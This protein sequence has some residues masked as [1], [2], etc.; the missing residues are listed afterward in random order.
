MQKQDYQE[1]GEP[2]IKVEDGSLLDKEDEKPE[3]SE[4]A[5]EDEDKQMPEFVA[6]EA[7][8]A[9][10]GF[11]VLQMIASVGAGGFAAYVGHFNHETQCSQP[12]ATWLFITG[13]TI[14]ALGLLWWLALFA[15]KF[16]RN[17]SKV[18]NCLHKMAAAVLCLS[19]LFFL[20]W[21]VMGHVWI[22]SSSKNDCDEALYLTGLWFIVGVYMYLIFTMCLQCWVAMCLVC[23]AV[24]RPFR[25]DNGPLSEQTPLSPHKSQAEQP[26]V[27]EHT[28][29]QE[30]HED[31]S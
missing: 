17:G 25:K 27:P 11:Y 2:T 26:L 9:D 18:R 21:W 31:H 13:A 23:C 3:E 24:F 12:I 7:K 14:V 22:F 29:I 6:A 8:R 30:S 20:A 28:G 1:I 10:V 5:P 16:L 4:K 15:L 19:T